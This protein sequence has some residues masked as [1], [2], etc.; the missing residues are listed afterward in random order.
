MTEYQRTQT[1]DASAGEVFAWLSDVNN[2]PQYLPPVVDASIEGASAEGSPGQRVRATLEYP[3][4]AGTFDAE[5][6]FAVDDDRRRMEWGAEV[7]RDYSGW[8]EVA[9]DAD[10]HSQVTVHLNFGERSVEPEVREQTLEERDPLAEGIAATLESIR[11]Q[12]EE[13]SGK[14]EPPPPRPG[15]EPPTG[16]NP[17]V[18]DDN[19][20]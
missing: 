17:A 1:I 16:D 19:P 8:L 3:G 5:G 15:A 9:E 6:Y 12:I 11:R 4:G 14:V 13:G 2:L 20:S 18:V 7:Q 10:G